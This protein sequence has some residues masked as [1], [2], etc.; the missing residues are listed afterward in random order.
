MSWVWQGSRFGSH[1]SGAHLW[2]RLRLCLLHFFSSLLSH[3]AMSVGDGRQAGVIAGCLS[4]V[5]RSA[6]C[7]INFIRYTSRRSMVPQHISFCA[8]AS[9]S[10]FFT[11]ILVFVQTC[12]ISRKILRHFLTKSRLWCFLTDVIRKRFFQRIVWGFHKLRL[13]TLIIKISF[14]LYL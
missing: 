4:Q 11:S 9:S 1:C 6:K 2:W 10:S 5:S 13:I 14:S 12:L 3:G 7:L 8:V